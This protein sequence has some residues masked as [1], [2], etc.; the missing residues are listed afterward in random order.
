MLSVKDIAKIDFVYWEGFILILILASHVLSWIPD[1][2]A[3]II[4]L[5]GSLEIDLELFSM[6]ILSLLKKGSY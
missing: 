3:Q 1:G 4:R 5:R 6:V 2:H